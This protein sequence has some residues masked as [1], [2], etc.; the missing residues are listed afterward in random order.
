MAGIQSRLQQ[1]TTNKMSRATVLHLSGFADS[2]ENPESALVGDVGIDKIEKGV[3]G[4]GG[5]QL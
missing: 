1:S 2:T 3:N 5:G 4:R